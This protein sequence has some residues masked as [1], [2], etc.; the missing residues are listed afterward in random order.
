MTIV[1][2]DR[3]AVWRDQPGRIF[4]DAAAYADFDTWHEIATGLRETSPV[5]EVALPGREPFWALT[6]HADVMEV[7]RDNARFLSAPRPLLAPIAAEQL[8]IEKGE[9]LRTLI[10][11]DE[12]DHKAYRQVAATR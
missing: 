12:P 7:E 8:A 2:T 11:M 5:F 10:H 1:T 9:V 4:V 3:R 6:R